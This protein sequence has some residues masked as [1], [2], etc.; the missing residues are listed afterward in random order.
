MSDSLTASID[1]DRD[2]EDL[3]TLSPAAKFVLAAIA[4]ETD[5]GAIS[6]AEFGE[7]TLLCERTIAMSVRRLR[8]TGLVTRCA[9]PPRRSPNALPASRGS[10]RFP[11]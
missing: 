1:G 5:T 2:R 6:R 4:A 8:E 3:R 9:D 11:H 10:L 7:R